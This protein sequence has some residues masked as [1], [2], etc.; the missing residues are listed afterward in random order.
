V[1]KP[2]MF[3][4]RVQ[5]FDSINRAFHIGP[6]LRIPNVAI[7]TTSL[8]SASIVR[9]SAEFPRQ[10]KQWETKELYLDCCCSLGI[11]LSS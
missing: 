5:D 8:G 4:N 6:T 11:L 10:S 1:R 3:P 7:A 9:Q 2:R